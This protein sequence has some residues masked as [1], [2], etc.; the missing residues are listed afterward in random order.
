MNRLYLTA[1]VAALALGTQAQA[2]SLAI[3]LKTEPNSIDPHFNYSAVNIAPLSNIYDPLVESD[4]VKKPIPAL[5]TSWTALDD[6]RWEIKLRQGVTFHD[7]SPLTPRDVVYSWC[8][9]P[10]IE[11]SPSSYATFVNKMASIEI[12]D[13]STLIFTTKEPNPLMWSDLSQ[14]FIISAAKMGAEETVTFGAEGCTGMGEVPQ[15]AVFSDLGY[16]MGTGPY[17]VTEFNRGEALRL[18]AYDG[19]WGDKPDYDDVT[20]RTISS[21]GPRV[22][23]LLAGDVQLIES[24]PIQDIER[25]KGEGFKTTETKSARVIYLQ[26]RQDMT[27]TPPMMEAEGNPLHDQRVRQAISYAINRQGIVDRIMGGYAEAAGELLAPPMFGTTGRAVDPYDPEKAKALLAEAGYGDG[28]K[29]TLGAPNDRYVNDERVAQAIA[30]MLTQVGI[31]TDVDATTASQFFSR[32]NKLDFGMFMAGWGSSSGDTS[33]PLNAMVATANK[34]IG[35]GGWNYGRYSNPV[36]DEK[37]A[38]ALVTVD[39]AERE[40]LL[41]E[42]ETIALDEFGI[43]PLH[44]ELTVWAMAPEVHYEPRS[45]QRTAA[46]LVEKAE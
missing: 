36:V 46:Y 11:N 43:L 30:Q 24:P 17:K 20:I 19:F 3:A 25:I 33:S 16:A 39:D 37:I 26:L 41:Q 13:D 28:F 15:S 10:L 21:D 45:D 27:E 23:A 32:R 5:A 1:A 12:V 42:A 14:I 4:A 6:L 35:A 9:A 7:G 8:R 18:E 40:K 38:K 2:E 44:Y 31:T 29:V 34:D 22:A